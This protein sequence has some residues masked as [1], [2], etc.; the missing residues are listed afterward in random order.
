MKLRDIARIEPG[1]E[2]YLAYSR[3]NDQQCALIALYQAPGSNAVELVQKAV[4]TMGELSKSFPSGMRYDIALDT[5][6]PIVAGI[7]EIVQTLFIALALVLFVVFIFIQDWRATLIP[8][9]AI[10]VSL[11]GAFMVFPLLGFTINVL[12]LL[13]RAGHRYRGGRRHRGS[14]G[15]S[16]KH[17]KGDGPQRGHDSSHECKPHR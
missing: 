8:T 14:G 6:K 9:I 3:M 15:R 12:S 4:Q 17:R 16:G 10:P 1:G 2:K 7:K 11:V 13:G 5:S